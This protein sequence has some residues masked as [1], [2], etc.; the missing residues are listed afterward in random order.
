MDANFS[1]IKDLHGVR[2]A[3]DEDSVLLP[4][5]SVN[6]TNFTET[7][8]DDVN[9]TLLPIS[10]TSS[11]DIFTILYGNGTSN[12]TMIEAPDR[13]LIVKIILSVLLGTMILA[14]IVG[15]SD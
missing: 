5:H 12:E 10:N 11:E 1:E 14:T 15:E 8:L 2:I 3:D 7:F 9:T 6:N 4:W 13:E